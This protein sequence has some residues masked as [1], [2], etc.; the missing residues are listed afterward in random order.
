MIYRY[1]WQ[2]YRYAWQGT[3]NCPMSSFDFAIFCRQ[4]PEGD[5]LP[6]GKAVPLYLAATTVMLGNHRAIKR[7]IYRYAW[8][9]CCYTWQ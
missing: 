9:A 3:S 4:K 8:Q 7:M 6:Q 5:D 2:N 1:A